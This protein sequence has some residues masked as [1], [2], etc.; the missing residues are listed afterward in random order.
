METFKDLPVVHARSPKDWNKWL[1]KHHQSEK[2]VWL[3]ISHKNSKLKSINHDEAVEEALC[4]GW[5]DSVTYK[6]DDES[7]YQ[8]FS[9]RKPNGNWSNTNREK[10][11]MLIASKRMQPAGQAMIDLAKQNGRWDVLMD[12]QNGI[13]PPDLLK[14]LNKNKTALKNF[15][16]FSRSSK[17]IIL[18]WITNAKRPE[19]RLK[20][21]TQTV[22]LAAQN[23][24]ANHP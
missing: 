12:V 24:K 22:E 8:R 23:I 6:R 15:E 1:S 13:I 10:A 20:R 7:R 5:I 21:I 2:S 9:P 19:T 4:F 18:E 14:L 16:A 11:E 17:R 3:I